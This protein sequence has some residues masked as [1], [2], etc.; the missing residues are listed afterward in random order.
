MNCTLEEEEV[1]V[2]L[3]IVGETSKRSDV[4]LNSISVTSSIVLY[5]TLCTSTK[6]VDLVV[7]L[8]SVMVAELTSTGTGPL[9]GGWMPSSDTSN[10]SQTSV[11]FTWEFLDTESLNN[12]LNSM[13]TSN[14][15]SVNAFVIRE[16]L[17]ELN[18]L[19]EM[20]EG[21]LNFVCNFSTI[22]LDLHNVSLVL[23]EFEETNLGGNEDTDDST[24]L[25]D[26]FEVTVDR[27]GALSVFLES[28]SVLGESL[29]FSLS[30]V[31]VETALYISIKLLSP[32]SRELSETTWSFDITDKSNNLDWWAFD[33]GC[34]VDDILLKDLLT[35][36]TLLIFD[37]V[38]HTSLIA[39]ESS[40]VDWL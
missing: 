13:T 6:T 15:N 16:D 39:N 23:A 19:L 30:P 8:C 25:L 17:S 7:D 12:T 37:D 22:K 35:F 11:S 9:Y 28:I 3:T 33:D 32:N 24:V 40:E 36:T 2:D 20:I 29:L 26:S 10:F 27:A 4:L 14:S 1:V 34:C 21:K 31:S 38:S 18:L 5:S